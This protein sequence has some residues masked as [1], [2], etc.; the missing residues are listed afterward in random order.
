MLVAPVEIKSR[1]STPSTEGARHQLKKLLGG[2]RYHP[3]RKYY[4]KMCATDPTLHQLLFDPRN[5]KRVCRELFQLLHHVYSYNVDHCLLIVGTHNDLLYA[6]EVKFPS[7]LLQCYGTLMDALYERHFS[8]LYQRTVSEDSF[9][10]EKVKMALDIHNQGKQK[11]DQIDWYAFHTNYMLWRGLNV[12]IDVHAIKFPLPPM[13]MFIPCQNVEWNFSKGPSNTLTK[14]FD[15]SEE[16]ITI[17]CPQTLATA[18][19]LS[20]SAAAFHRSVQMIKSK[21]DIDFYQSID[22]Y[23]KAANSR[24][25]YKKS[26]GQ[27]ANFLKTEMAALQEKEEADN[28]KIAPTILQA[29]PP[30]PSSPPSRTTRNTSNIPTQQWNVKWQSG[31]TPSKLP[32][33]P[34]KRETKNKEQHR[35]RRE[36]CLGIVLCS[37]GDGSRAPCELCGTSTFF[38]CSGC[39][40]SLC[41][42]VGNNAM[43]EKKIKMIRRNLKLPATFEIPTHNKLSHYN[44]QS[45]ERTEIKVLNSCYHIA[46]S[47][48]FTSFFS[49]KK[50]IETVSISDD[51]NSNNENG[52]N[53]N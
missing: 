2:E 7:D 32:G 30:L 12:S 46:H 6:V 51:E 22:N 17:R 14:L 15:D 28:N 36:E 40:S 1:V 52:N 5:T 4:F 39:R 33:R 49:R 13:D 11:G 3:Q 8:F 20:V 16:N 31:N 47:R 19:F 21:D 34:T 50:N 26:L 53:E 43:T 35:Q 42:Q 24:S 38:F 45:C 37:K 29:L 10:V 23:R 9:P 25:S 27:L 41:F 48:K 44:P 18:R